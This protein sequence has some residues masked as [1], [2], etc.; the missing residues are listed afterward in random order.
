MENTALAYH[1]IIS[2]LYSSYITL[3]CQGNW[4]GVV[5]YR[6]PAPAL[7]KLWG[8]GGGGGGG[9]VTGDSWHIFFPSS[10]KLC[11]I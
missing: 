10:K 2:S 5:K 1:I 9:G 11:K 3:M 4:L 7:K 6:I 8:G